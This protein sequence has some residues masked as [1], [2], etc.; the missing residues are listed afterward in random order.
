VRPGLDFVLFQVEKSQKNQGLN[1]GTLAFLA[2]LV[3]NHTN[4]I[5]PG[6]PIGSAGSALLLDFCVTVY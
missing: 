5:S 4:G 3:T 1:L 6:F 2:T